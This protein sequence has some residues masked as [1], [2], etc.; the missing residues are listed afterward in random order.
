MN[1]FEAVVAPLV[2]T[3]L[4][5]FTR[6]YQIGKSDKVTWD[7]A[8]FGKFGSYYLK[9]EYYFDVHPPLGKM[10]VGL[11]GYLAGYN[12]SFTFESGV[13]YPDWVDYTSMRVFNAMF[14]V[15]CVP[16]AY[17]T[18][19]N[20]NFRLPTV[21]LVTLMILFEHSY[22]TLAK[23]IL[24]D[25]MLAFFTFAVV[26]CWSKFHTLQ[27]Q[28]F[29]A[30]WWFWLL[31]TGLN[32]GCVTSVKMV[33]LFVTSLVGAYT[34]V[35]LWIKFG[36]TKMPVKTYISHW[37]ARI[38]GFIVLPTLVFMASFKAHF[39]ILNHSGPG[40]ANMSS[41]FQANL[42]GND[43]AAGP[44][45]LAYGSRI[46][47]KSQGL[48]GGLLHSHVQT[49]PEGS[50]QQQVT[51][52]HHKDMNNEFV[53][54]YS[55]GSGKFYDNDGDLEFI[56]D[57]SVVRLMHPMTGRN[58]HTHQIKA[59]LTK[60][61]YEVSGY[62]NLTI[63]DEKDDWVVEIVETLGDE[64][65]NRVHPLSSAIR[66]KST[67]M[68][69][70]LSAEGNNLPHWGFRQGEVTCN[71]KASYRDK[72]TW[73]NIETHLNGRLNG[74]DAE[75]ERKLPKTKFLRDFVQLN[76]AM[77]ASN[78]ALVPDPDKV[79]ELASRAWEWPTLH[80]GLR[81]CGWG[82]ENVRYFLL[83]HPSTTW[84]TTAGLLVV[85]FVTLG[86]ILRWQRQYV[87]FTTKEI[88]HYAVA[89]LMPALGWFLHYLPF[90]VMARVTYVHHY[91]PAL[92]FAILTFGFL[93]DHITGRWIK[94]KYIGL[95]IYFAL[96]AVT[97]GLFIYFS[98]ISFG[99]TGDVADYNYL[100]WLSTWRI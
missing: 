14:G 62:G 71:P 69:C 83:G 1:K 51:T 89:G 85:G 4:A 100:N 63:G 40:D 39:V 87:D 25:S 45:D 27:N 33:G 70:Y 96:Y 58:I 61:K 17:F 55:R 6:L 91:L 43:V 60:G 64:D 13:D 23:F 35:D 74:T 34:V 24:L 99:M 59:P 5:L 31:L 21:W 46:T 66:L 20:L 73:W 15:G 81:L 76:F 98:P 36:D 90:V 3:G 95:I 48:N 38:F 16:L 65:S 92:Y 9:R 67:A 52:Y 7:E 2:F 30:K 11:S 8:H 47:L 84:L 49:Y 41:L 79:D 53:L 57:G 77:M 22:V 56:E 86:Y 32:I 18:A 88:E 72:R 75:K 80:V 68:N 12:G 37:I 54:E 78:N 44:I 93:I 10:L 94:N 19:K 29:S 82:K 50:E 97:I 26:A 42:I 28:S